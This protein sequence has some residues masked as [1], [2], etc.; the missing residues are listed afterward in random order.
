MEEKKKELR[1]K[2][3]EIK[4]PN[5][6]EGTFISFIFIRQLELLLI[7]LDDDQ[8]IVL[9]TFQNKRNRLEGNKDKSTFKR[10]KIQENS[11]SS[12]SSSDSESSNEIKKNIGA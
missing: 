9:K 10:P 7:N 2:I 3:A 5:T 4:K 8:P 1:S 11:S 6:N 12:E